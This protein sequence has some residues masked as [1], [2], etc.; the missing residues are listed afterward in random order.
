MCQ[1]VFFFLDISSLHL[2]SWP[3]AWV[4][5]NEDE[6][7][8]PL[9]L[10]ATHISWIF[11][12]YHVLPYDVFLY[13]SLFNPYPPNRVSCSH[14]K[15]LKSSP[16]FQARSRVNGRLRAHLF[17]VSNSFDKLLWIGSGFR[18][19]ALPKE[20]CA[21]FPKK[22]LRKKKK[23]FFPKTTVSWLCQIVSWSRI[24]RI[25]VQNIYRQGP[26]FFIYY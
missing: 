13:F 2:S 17:F 14:L 1:I 26:I 7:Q 20:C 24:G 11:H 5:F 18:S 9:F 25:N 3:A 16:I 12:V 21:F 23:A 15:S 10:A 6:L 8:L 22:V 4:T 19:L